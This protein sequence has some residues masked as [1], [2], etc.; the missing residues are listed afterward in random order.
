MKNFDRA[1]SANISQQYP[2]LYWPIRYID[3][4]RSASKMNRGYGSMTR[5]TARAAD[6]WVELT[7]A[8]VAN[9]TFQNNGRTFLLIQGTVGSVKPVSPAGALRVA[10]QCFIPECY[11][12]GLVARL[13]RCLEQ[14]QISERILQPRPNGRHAENGSFFELG[15]SVNLPDF[16]MLSMPIAGFKSNEGPARGAEG[17]QSRSA[18]GRPCVRDMMNMRLDPDSPTHFRGSDRH[19]VERGVRG[20]DPD[21]ARVQE[22]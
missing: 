17:G 18:P 7:D 14:Q 3:G 4:R 8:D 11:T 19:S 6:D 12:G 16:D 13:R 15:T 22:Q 10:S 9:I 1:H 20:C 2:Y 5:P 21:L